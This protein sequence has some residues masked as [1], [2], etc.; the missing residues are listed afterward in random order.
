ML[1]QSREEWPDGWDGA[2]SFGNLSREKPW[3]EYF[4]RK[5]TPDEDITS[6][7]P[8][9]T[10][11]SIPPLPPTFRTSQS[12]LSSLP[13][14]TPSEPSPFRSRTP[15]SPDGEIEDCIEVQ[16]P[17]DLQHQRQSTSIR[18][19]LEQIAATLELSAE[20]VDAAEQI[21]ARVEKEGIPRP[22]LPPNMLARAALLAASRQLGQPKTF[23]EMERD[24]PKAT[25][26]KFH[27]H[28]K[29]V[30]SILKADVLMSPTKEDGDSYFHVTVESFISTVANALKLDQAVQ[31]R[32]V[33]I[34]RTAEVKDLFG[35]KRPNAIAAVILS[36]AAECEEVYKGSEPYAKAS[37]LSDAT[38]QSSQRMLLRM[39]EDMLKRGPLP[40]PFRAPWNTPG[41]RKVHESQ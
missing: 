33:A 21:C 38:I 10:D 1:A 3:V 41:Y 30:D 37:G 12:P 14:A 7:R 29:H 19:L 20:C 39:V 26:S 11:L 25:R 15:A 17:P 36:F 32:A 24:L 28:F 34:A 16:P 13:S 23:V 8:A 2:A 22:K 40:P 6:S 31:Q 4:P 5:Q 35:G 9:T 18:A 27:K